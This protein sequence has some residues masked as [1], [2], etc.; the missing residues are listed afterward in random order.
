MSNS[1]IVVSVIGLL[2]AVT[3]AG[4][5]ASDAKNGDKPTSLD[6]ERKLVKGGPM[7]ADAGTRYLSAQGSD[8]AAMQAKMNAQIQAYQNKK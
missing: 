6:Q 2:A 7:P 1:R 5:N 4:C 8:P 3:I